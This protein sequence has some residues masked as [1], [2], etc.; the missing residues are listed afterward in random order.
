MKKGLNHG[1][2]G[3]RKPVADLL[4]HLMA[5]MD[6]SHLGQSVVKKLR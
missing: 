4:F 6:N 2:P 1:F 5:G 3:R